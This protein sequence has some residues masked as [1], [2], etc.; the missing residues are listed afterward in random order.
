MIKYILEQY[1]QLPISIKKIWIAV[2]AVS[3]FFILKAYTNHLINQYNYSF[4]W[5]LVSLKVGL[6]YIF[7]VSLMPA[8]YFLTKRLQNKRYLRLT[9]L[10]KFLIGCILLA[11]FHQLITSRADDFINYLNSGYMKAFLGRN[12]ISILIIGSFTSFIELLVIIAVFLALDY[13]KR[14][15]RNQKALI[16]S[17][18]DALRTKLHPHFLFNTLHSIAS[19]IDIDTKNAQRM[20]SKL[21][22]LLRKMLEYD[23]K[24]M[25]TVA[26]ELKFIRDYLDLEQIRYHDRITIDY[27][28]SEKVLNIKI[29][30]MIFQPLVENAIKHGAIPAVKKGTIK[31]DINI[32]YSDSLKE[33]TLIMQISNTVNTTNRAEKVKGTGF[34]LL[35]ITKRLQQ[36]YQNK[37]LFTSNF[38]TPELY[39]AKINIPIIL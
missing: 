18:L 8:A 15:F 20:I 22:D 32:E 11:T 4:S 9:E 38:K 27:T 3:L 25:V 23:A 14:Y 33:D 19:M 17:Q 26:E 30:N 28:V 29:P 24:Q 39:I 1:K 21:G 5:L 6:T 35:N 31:I 7:W 12:N 37:F 13:Q 36:F 34:G 2:F 16:T 10:L